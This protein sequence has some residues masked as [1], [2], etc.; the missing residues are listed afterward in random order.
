L[1][2]EYPQPADSG[3]TSTSYGLEPAKPDR[4]KYCDSMIVTERSR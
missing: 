4:N 2:E 1:S 3:V